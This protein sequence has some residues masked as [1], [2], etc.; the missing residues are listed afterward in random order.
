LPRAWC[1]LSLA[2]CISPFVN[3]E[4]TQTFEDTGGTGEGHP[5]VVFQASQ[6]LSVGYREPPWDDGRLPAFGIPFGLL[7]DG[8]PA[9]DWRRMFE[10]PL[11]PPAVGDWGGN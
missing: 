7:P 4:L 3:D 11:R 1:L 9:G 8:G 6:R 5:Q 2:C 10:S